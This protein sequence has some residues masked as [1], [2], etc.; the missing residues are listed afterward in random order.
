MSD[1]SILSG[2]SYAGPGTQN[3]PRTYYGLS[4]DAWARI[5]VLALLMIGLFWPNL[6]RLW[7]KTN[8][9]TGQA[10]WGHAF[11]IPLIGIYYLY[12]NREAL[13]KAPIRSSP[14]KIPLTE[15]FWVNSRAWSA[16]QI[17]WKGLWV[18]LAAFGYL[19]LGPTI[20]FVI[21]LIV[22]ALV[23]ARYLPSNL[24]GLLIM[25]GG[26]LLYG[27]GIWPGP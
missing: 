7:L 8:P 19:S 16:A 10:N 24:L 22:G 1:L 4:S 6:R 18:C 9:V 20:A 21:T 12:L 13:L 14:L 5:G 23:L 11:F 17:L 26:I 2:V 3:A 27:Y 15:I 25:A